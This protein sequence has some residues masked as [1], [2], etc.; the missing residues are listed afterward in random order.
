MA[1]H[2]G[3]RRWSAFIQVGTLTCRCRRKKAFW[4]CAAHEG[5]AARNDH[6]SKQDLYTLL[7]ISSDASPQDIKLA[8]RKLA[9]QYHPDVNSNS[10]AAEVFKSIRVAYETLADK[11][12]R[13]N[14]DHS[15]RAQTYAVRK[16]VHK[17][18]Q[19]SSMYGRRTRGHYKQARDSYWKTT[20]NEDMWEFNSSGNV[21]QGKYSKY[22]ECGEGNEDFGCD[23]D[24]ETYAKHRGPSLRQGWENSIIDVLIVFCLVGFIWHALG[25]QLA[26][27]YFVFFIPHNE[28]HTLWYRFASLLAWVIGGTKGLVLQYGIVTTGW[29]YGK[30]HDTVLAFILFAVWMEALFPR[31]FS[32]PHGAILLMAHICIG[33]FVPR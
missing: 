14:Y 23:D 32:L 19:H 7:G 17:N 2:V 5:E 3:V 22:Y 21:G 31:A 10:G 15:L 24:S 6:P 16:K 9:R 29:L 4:V 8:F 1:E 13:D 30:G 11:A 25:A 27:T 33:G 18:Y 20:A 26:L 28:E 12:S